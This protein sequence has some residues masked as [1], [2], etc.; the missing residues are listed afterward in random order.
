[1]RSAGEA[2][3][4]LIQYINR[5]WLEAGAVKRLARELEGLRVKRPLLCTDPGIV[6]S[7]LLEKLRPHWPAAAPFT[8]FDATP[9][10]PTAGAV[11]AAHD[12]YR[13]QAC[14]GLIGLGGGSPMDLAKGVA[15]M[16]AQKE[17]LEELEVNRK[18]TTKIGPLPPL[19]GIPTH[20]GRAQGD[21]RQ[22]ASRAASCA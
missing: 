14:D 6:A 17:P 19:I 9:A 22:P 15:L 21:L 10:N 2:P 12:L 11:R 13:A 20:R 8:V 1:M 18:G 3:M 5:A 4:A 7:G 16:L